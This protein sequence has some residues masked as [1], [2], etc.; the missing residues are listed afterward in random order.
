MIVVCRKCGDIRK[1]CYC[2]LVAEV[3][4]LRD[5][6]ARKCDLC[7]ASTDARAWQAENEALRQAAERLKGELRNMQR[8]LEQKNRA[9]DALHYVWCSGGCKTG[10]HRWSEQTI[11]EEVVKE[12]E[13][14]TRRL[15]TWW[16][17]VTTKEGRE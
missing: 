3:K 8:S 13:R 14:N 15:R 9:L 12:A 7:E 1:P 10:T 5:E 16:D 6:L 2:S 11:T 17:N 4:T